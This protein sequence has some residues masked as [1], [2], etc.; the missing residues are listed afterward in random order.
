MR[1]GTGARHRLAIAVGLSGGLLTLALLA[2]NTLAPTTAPAST[3]VL[4][5][6]ADFADYPEAIRQ[7]LSAGGDAATLE[8][9]LAGWGALPPEA[10][11]Q[12][13]AAD[14]T[15]DGHAEIVVALWRAGGEAPSGDLLIF[16]HQGGQYALLYQQGVE[17]YWMT[18]RLLNILDANE[19]GHPDVAYTLRTCGA[20]TCFD[21]LEI[22][23]WEETGFFSLMGGKLDMPYPTYT[24]SPG[25]IDALSGQIGSVGAEPQRGYSEVW[26]WSDDISAFTVTQEIWELPIYRYHALLDGDRAMLSGDYATAIAAYER[27]IDDDTLQEWTV[28]P[29]EERA[30]LAAFARW[31]LVLTYLQG[32]DQGKGSDQGNAQIQYTRLQAGYPVGAVGHD[33]AALAEIFWTA[34]LAN[35]RITDGC[36]EVT[37]AIEIGGPILDFF[38]ANYGYANPRWEMV[39]LCPFVE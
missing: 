16:G 26:E 3:S 17:P 10:Q 34:Y 14:L 7:Y 31:R 24:V 32:S 19:D 30:Q 18:T 15:G 13:L 39:D 28:T 29:A 21:T 5:K 22:V 27:A 20:H 35:G 38:N 12:V 2:C 6:P 37:A 33:A 36:I 8:S 1:S 23:G 25:R 4:A 9:T 11:G